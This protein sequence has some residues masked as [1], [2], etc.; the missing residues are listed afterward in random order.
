MVPT[1]LVLVLTRSLLSSGR[2]HLRKTCSTR[3]S[4]TLLPSFFVSLHAVLHC[5]PAPCS[6][7]SLPP[8]CAS[9]VAARW[10]CS[11]HRPVRAVI[12]RHCQ[13]RHRLHC[14]LAHHFRVLVTVLVLAARSMPPP[15]VQGTASL[16]SWKPTLTSR[17]PPRQTPCPH[18]EHATSQSCTIHRE[19]RSA[20]S[21]TTRRL[22]RRW[23]ARSGREH[24]S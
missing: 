22:P 23:Q 10:Q 16:P 19:R 8:C 24:E 1:A 5:D 9:C 12:T 17:E 4:A 11:R 3:T 2:Q 13:Q 15:Q 6:T 7:L 21:C 20:P 18:P 14:L